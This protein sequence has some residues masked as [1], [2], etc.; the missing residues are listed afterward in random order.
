MKNTTFNN[1][2]V[3]LFNILFA[4]NDA[5]KHGAII[6][7]DLINR[8]NK[9]SKKIAKAA[10]EAMNIGIKKNLTY[11]TPRRKVFPKQYADQKTRLILD[12]GSAFTDAIYVKALTDKK[13]IKEMSEINDK[14]LDYLRKSPAKTKASNKSK[15]Q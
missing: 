4:F 15:K 9:V 1:Q 11:D 10:S 13:V 12:I 2:S 5:V 3:K 6:D 14:L 7:A 8:I